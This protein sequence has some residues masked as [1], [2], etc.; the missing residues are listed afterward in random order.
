MTSAV[1][2][3]RPSRADQSAPAVGEHRARLRL[4]RSTPQVRRSRITLRPAAVS[5]VLVVGA[6]LAVVVGNMALASGQ[7]HLD[8][9]QQRL[10]QVES[11]MASQQERYQELVSP[12][13]IAHSAQLHGDVQPAATYTLPY[14][15]DLSKRLPAP[16]FSSYPCCSVTPRR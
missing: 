14:V 8:N 10:A 13:Q 7:L 16:Q 3:A 2:A 9:L 15:A 12:Q 11:D 6:L 1:A 5:A 4:A